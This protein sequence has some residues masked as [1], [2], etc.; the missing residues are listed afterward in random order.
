MVSL[1]QKEGIPQIGPRIF[2]FSLTPEEQVR[3]LL[4]QATKKKNKKLIAVLYPNSNYGKTL[5]STMKDMAPKFGAEVSASQGYASTANVPEELRQLKF[6][7]SKTSPTAPLGFDTLFIPDSYAAVLK[8]IPAL[9]NSGIDG[10]LLLGTN[11]WNDPS[12]AAKSGGLLDQSVF[13]DIYFKDS[14]NPQVKQFVSEY[15]TA[16]GTAPSTLE[17]MGYDI[18]RFVGQALQGRKGG[19]ANEIEAAVSGMHGYRGVTGLRSFLP[20]READVEPYLL[21]VEGGAIK[22]LK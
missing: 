8:I 16:Y 13:L 4:D 7:V 14:D 19:N 1:A 17:A 6:S 12:L 9:K 11:A 18:V 3:A 5:M 15:S 21:T 20:E 10:L 2:R 22:E